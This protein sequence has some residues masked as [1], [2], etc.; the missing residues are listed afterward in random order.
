MASVTMY[1]DI[2]ERFLEGEELG[3]LRLVRQ[4]SW[5][6]LGGYYTHLSHN[7]NRIL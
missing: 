7:S 6:R 3:Y 4:S 5:I 1:L 2:V